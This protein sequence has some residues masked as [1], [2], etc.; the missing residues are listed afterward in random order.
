[1]TRIIKIKEDPKDKLLDIARKM[2]KQNYRIVFY[3]Y[4]K[5]ALKDIGQFIRV[6][7]RGDAP[8]D[9]GTLQKRTDFKVKQWNEIV[10]GVFEPDMKEYN[11]DL[12]KPTT[13]ISKYTGKVIPEFKLYAKYV[14]EK[15]PYYEEAVDK[16]FAY[17][18]K[19]NLIEFNEKYF[20]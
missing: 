19:R 17:E 1:M 6:I 9:T 4:M 11:K 13:N 14:L 18:L 20:D 12:H 16:Y 7:A 3:N 5:A 8:F 15:N 10:F 2:E